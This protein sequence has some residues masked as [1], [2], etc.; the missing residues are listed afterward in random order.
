MKNW[1]QTILTQYSASRRLLSVIDTFNQAVSLDDF[2]DEFIEK[3]WDLTT[4]ETF[5]LDMWGKIVGIGRY[6]TVPIESWAFGFGEADMPGAEWPT[7]FNDA[8]FVGEQQETT[9]VRLED[10]AYR[11]LILCKAFTNISI[12]TIP[13]MNRFL[14]MLFRRRGRAFCTN[15]REMTMGVVTEF[16]LA[17][18]EKMIL[19]NFDVMP[20]PSG[21]WVSVHQIVSPWWGFASD[22]FPF[23]DGVFNE[24]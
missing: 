2:T 11:T 19:T 24:E 1:E 12:A 23:N 21:V 16:V 13:D 15:Y 3:V 4:C 7:P 18:W 9:N 8:P 20:I 10:A 14:E 17:P 22:A 5:G 6:I